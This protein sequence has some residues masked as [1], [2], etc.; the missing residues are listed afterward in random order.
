MNFGARLKWAR[1]RKGLSQTQLGDLVNVSHATINRYENGVSEPSI[2]MIKKLAE[3]LDVSVEFLIEGVDSIKKHKTIIDNIDISK[4]GLTDE[5][6]EILDMI[7]SNPDLTIMFKDLKSAPEQRIR[8][9]IT[10][11][12]IL[13]RDDG[14]KKAP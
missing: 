3:V 10:L 5:D 2:D 1:K 8:D 4:L 12:K 6:L 9:L 14:N 7:R 11:W 13:N